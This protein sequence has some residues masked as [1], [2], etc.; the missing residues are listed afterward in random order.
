MSG[1]LLWNWIEEIQYCGSVYALEIL[2]KG[3]LSFSI[4]ATL[5]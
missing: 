2:S 4:S 1:N 3:Y 5:G